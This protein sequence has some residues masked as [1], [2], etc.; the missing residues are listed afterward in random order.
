[1]AAAAARPAAV[2]TEGNH[3]M[4]TYVYQVVHEDG[5]EGE[6]FEIVQHMSD[7]AITEHPETHDILIPALKTAACEQN[8]SGKGACAL[9]NGE[10][11]GQ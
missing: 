5:T 11:A 9:G 7:P 10:R 8:H 6:I 3:A 4:P 2:I 1:M